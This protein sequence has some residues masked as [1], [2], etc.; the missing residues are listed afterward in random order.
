MLGCVRNPQDRAHRAQLCTVEDRPAVWRRLGS[1]RP[2]GR[3]TGRTMFPSR[4]GGVACARRFCGPASCNLERPEIEATHSAL[5]YRV[6]K[7]L[8]APR[9]TLG[10][11]RVG[12]LA[13]EQS[14]LALLGFSRAPMVAGTRKESMIETPIPHPATQLGRRPRSVSE[15]LP[16]RVGRSITR[17]A[18][19]S[20]RGR[21]D[22]GGASVRRPSRHQSV[23]QWAHCRFAFRHARAQRANAPATSCSVTT[24]RTSCSRGVADSCRPPNSAPERVGVPAQ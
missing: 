8:S 10:F 13:P 20:A 9:T 19:S 22:A 14:H 24:S 23:D 4:L 2:P 21:V 11:V 17:P 7:G 1:S 18:A 16:R 6:G 3:W 12:L 5:L 15:E